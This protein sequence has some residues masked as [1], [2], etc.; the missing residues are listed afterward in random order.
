MLL[1]DTD[2]QSDSHGHRS[3]HSAA[4]TDMEVT[5]SRKINTDTTRPATKNRHD[6]VSRAARFMVLECFIIRADINAFA[7]MSIG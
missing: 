2:D 3:K 6:R 7:C 4:L 5:K 1:V